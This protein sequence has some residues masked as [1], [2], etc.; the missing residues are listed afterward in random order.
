[1]G[2]VGGAGVYMAHTLSNLGTHQFQLSEFKDHIRLE[3]TDDDPAA[4]RSLDAAVFAVEKWTGRLMRSGTVTQESGYYRPP[5]RAEVGSPTNIGT[6][7]EVD[8]AAETT[9]D[10][11]SK[12]YLMTSAGW[13]YAA[14]RPDKSCEYRKYYRWQYAVN[15]PDIEQDLKLCVF[16]LGAN[17]YENREQVQQNINLSKLPIGYRSLLDN[18]RDGA[19]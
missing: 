12:F 4:Q 6:I 1:V 13:W 17:F 11:T 10:V 2:G 19:M 14:V 8:A 7:T 5:F 16:G 18:F 3:I 9:T 15:T